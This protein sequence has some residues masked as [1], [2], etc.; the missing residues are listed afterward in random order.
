MS[1]EEQFVGQGSDRDETRIGQWMQS[2]RGQKF[3]PMDPRPDEIHLV[4]IAHALS[5]IC[6][7]GG[8]CE[9][10]Y[11]V[12]EHSVHASRI[13]CDGAE[14]EALMHDASE[15]YLAD[16]PRPIKHALPDYRVAER[17][18]EVA[19]A[20]RFSLFFPTPP[21]VKVA[22]NQMLRIEAKAIMKDPPAAWFMGELAEPTRVVQIECWSPAV[23]EFKFLTRAAELGIH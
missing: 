5:N 1:M 14:Q 21:S 2:F 22:D 15:A 19:I 3:Y 8:H 18:W 12:A 13:V 7:Y 23:A 10:F 9:R 20:E 4:D 16:L 6:R 11:S 17:K